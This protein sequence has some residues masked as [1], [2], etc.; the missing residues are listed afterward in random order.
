M[1][2]KRRSMEEI[3]RITRQA[4]GG[5]TVREVCREHNVHEVTFAQVRWLKIRRCSE[6]QEAGKRSRC[7]SPSVGR[8]SVHIGHGYDALLRARRKKGC[9][10]SVWRKLYQRHRWQVEGIH[11]EAKTQHGLHR[12]VRRERWNVAIQALLTASVINLKRLASLLNF[13][14]C[15]RDS[16]RL[17]A[18]GSSC[19][20]FDS[21]NS[22]QNF[23]LPL[24]LV[25]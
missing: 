2:Q 13:C 14:V 10:P 9:W 18:R 24:A 12:A 7:L 11:G 16:R 20:H 19:F 22:T 25:A 23:K 3:I 4:D 21:S 1:K 5:Q 17:I 8:R 6:A 15:L